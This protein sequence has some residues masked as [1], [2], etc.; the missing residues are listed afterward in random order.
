[1]SCFFERITGIFL[2]GKSWVSRWF[3]HHRSTMKEPGAPANQSRSSAVWSLKAWHPEAA[4]RAA[5]RLDVHPIFGSYLV[6]KCAGVQ[7]YTGI[8]GI[9][10]YGIY[11]IYI[12]KGKKNK[13]VHVRSCYIRPHDSQRLA[14]LSKI[15]RDLKQS[16][17]VISLVWGL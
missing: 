3:K 8:Y 6:H 1:M 15:G 13:Y 9:Y 5:K 12:F 4:K 11:I 7:M 14:H 17:P 10:I 16:E 2:P